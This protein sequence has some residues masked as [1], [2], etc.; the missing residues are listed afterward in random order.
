M[1]AVISRLNDNAGAAALRDDLSGE[2]AKMQAGQD[3]TFS[4]LI[5]ATAVCEGVGLD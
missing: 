3:N 2:L 4:L 5:V 1:E